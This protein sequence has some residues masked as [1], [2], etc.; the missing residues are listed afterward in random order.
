M[1]SKQAQG[2]TMA[3]GEFVARLKIAD[4]PKGALPVIRTG[5]ADCVGCMI[6]GSVE[7]RARRVHAALRFSR[8]STHASAMRNPVLTTVLV[9]LALV[10]I[11]VWGYTAYG[12]A[13]S[14]HMA[15][16]GSRKTGQ[17]AAILILILAGLTPASISASFS[18]GS[19]GNSSSSSRRA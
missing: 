5:F 17:A 19:S 8:N 12:A 13:L 15:E 1:A 7:D 11:V 9:L 4:A 16:Q 18:T 2:L 10:P 3:L 6:A 14:Y